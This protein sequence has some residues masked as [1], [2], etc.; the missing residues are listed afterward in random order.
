M[1]KISRRREDELSQRISSN[2][3][4]FKQNTNNKILFDSCLVYNSKLENDN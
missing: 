3:T 1:K 2:F 4:V